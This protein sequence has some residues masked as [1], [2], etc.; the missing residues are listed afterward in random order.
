MKVRFPF[1]QPCAEPQIPIEVTLRSCKFNGKPRAGSNPLWGILRNLGCGTRCQHTT[2]GRQGIIT[3]PTP[4]KGTAHCFEAT[5]V[6]A[7]LEQFN[8]P[9]L[10]E[11]PEPPA[12][13]NGGYRGYHSIP[14]GAPA[15]AS[16]TK[17]H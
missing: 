13:T 11:T 8:A 14:V 12:N 5:P 6:E 1:A 16:A 9:L 15:K 7:A 2:L 17:R 10:R 4:A 3:L